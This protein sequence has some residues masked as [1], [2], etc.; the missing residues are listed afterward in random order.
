METIDPR[1]LSHCRVHC[2][3]Q[4]MPKLYVYSVC[5]ELS[6]TVKEFHFARSSNLF[7]II[8]HPYTAD[9][10]YFTATTLLHCHHC[11][12]ARE[13]IYTEHSPLIKPTQFPL[14]AKQKN[15][16]S[17]LIILTI[18]IYRYAF[19]TIYVK[20]YAFS[21]IFISKCRFAPEH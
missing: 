9:T 10:I 5:A 7:I 21:C 11:M 16:L 19:Q 14:A 6:V 17:L 8:F 13:S 1:R 18:K 15:C 3:V 20:T 12:Y 4:Q 2:T